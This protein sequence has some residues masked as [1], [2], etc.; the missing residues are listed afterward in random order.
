MINKIQKSIDAITHTDSYYLSDKI[1]PVVERIQISNIKN[2]F[3]CHSK[4]E[5]IFKAFKIGFIATLYQDSHFLNTLKTIY[6]QSLARYT[7]ITCRLYHRRRHRSHHARVEHT[8]DHIIR[9]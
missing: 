6:R 2:K 7:A 1:E 4:S 3:N 8:G 5:L 9:R